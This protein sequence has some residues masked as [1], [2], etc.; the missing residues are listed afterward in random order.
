MICSCGYQTSDRS[1][2]RRHKRSCRT[3]R[4]AAFDTLHGKLCQVQD[5][6]R[7]RDAELI[8]CHRQI[9]RLEDR[10]TS[11][12]RQPQSKTTNVRDC[13]IFVTN[14]FPYASEPAVVAP[15]Q[16]HHLLHNVTPSDSVPKFV[17]LKHFC[18]PMASR[19]IY[20]PNRRGNTVLVVESSNDGQLRWVHRDRK[21]VIDDMLERNLNEL[22][23]SYCAEE[24]LPWREWLV[25]SGLSSMERRQTPAWKEQL[26]KLDL[27]LINHQRKTDSL[28][29]LQ[30]ICQTDAL[31]GTD[32]K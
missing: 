27:I 24:I 19:N 26:A 17:Q 2:F 1:N 18:G 22:C 13:N 3:V 5:Q 29:G 11:L 8:E 16:V 12:L 28:Q 23:R 31:S 21:G 10:V 15:E 20:L 25:A 7:R 6:L 30:H 14:V 9:A 4:D 32:N